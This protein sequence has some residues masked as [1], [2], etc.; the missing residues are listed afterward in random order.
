MEDD[1]GKQ[2][3]YL[4]TSQ[5]VFNPDNCVSTDGY[6]LSDQVIVGSAYAT[7]LAAIASGQQIYVYVSSSA[8]VNGRPE[9]E[10]IE[11]GQE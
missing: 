8:C 7:I 2:V 1:G 5:P 4:Q 9:V 6:E 10:T 11:I 3:I